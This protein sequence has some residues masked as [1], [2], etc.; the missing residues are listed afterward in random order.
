MDELK[1]F[2]EKEN[3]D[4]GILAVPVASANEAA[5]A[6]IEAGVKNIWNFV[7][8]DLHIDISSDT[9]IQNEHL[10]DGLLQ[11]SYTITA[12]KEKRRN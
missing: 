2:V 6:M 5:A 4:L 9:I 8:T 3:I 12:A 10:A 7:P 11:L 1:G